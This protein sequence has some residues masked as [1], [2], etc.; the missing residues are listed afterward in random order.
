[1]RVVGL[2]SEGVLASRQCSTWVAVEEYS[3]ASSV[4]VHST[5]ILDFNQRRDE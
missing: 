2:Y 5:H 3:G 1:M 4:V